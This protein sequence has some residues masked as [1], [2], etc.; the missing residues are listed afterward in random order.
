MTTDFAEMLDIFDPDINYFDN[1]FDC[2]ESTIQS[3]YINISN[4]N[5]IPHDSN[6]LSLI[7][8]N[9]RSFAANSDTM[10]NDNCFP[11]ILCLCETCSPVK[12]PKT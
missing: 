12:P 3:N 1:Q 11:D 9:I 5:K 6:K 7:S 4:F 2:I 10:F 8:Y